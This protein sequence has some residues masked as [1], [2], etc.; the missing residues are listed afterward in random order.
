MW[1]FPFRPYH[2]EANVECR[3]WQSNLPLV[4]LEHRSL[5][6]RISPWADISRPKD[7]F[8]IQLE[9]AMYPLRNSLIGCLNLNQVITAT[10]VTNLEINVT[11][12]LGTYI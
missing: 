6:N 10:K 1:S 3:Y 9:T 4:S 11:D 2:I 5:Y 8:P 12:S 7:C